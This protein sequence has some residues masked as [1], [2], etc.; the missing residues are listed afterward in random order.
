MVAPEMVKLKVKQV[1]DV[2]SVKGKLVS[3]GAI[4]NREEF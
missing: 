4:L 1:V 3:F 2:C